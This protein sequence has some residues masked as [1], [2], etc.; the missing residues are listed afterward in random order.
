MRRLAVAVIAVL[1]LSSPALAQGGNPIELGIDGA[2]SYGFDSPHIT[3]LSIPVNRLRVGF[4]TSPRVS[5]EPYGSLDYSHVNDNSSSFLNLG[6]G[7]LYHFGVA[8]NAPQPYVRPFA[9]LFH[10]SFDGNNGSTSSTAFALGGGVGVKIPIAN[11]FA[12]RLEGALR[13]AFEHDNIDS[14]TAFSAFFGLSFFTR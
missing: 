13:H 9:E 2:L 14:S 1:A 10:T 12:W 5:I 4:F 11:H 6:V 7:G 3:T 8:R